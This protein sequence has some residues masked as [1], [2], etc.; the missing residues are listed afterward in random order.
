VVLEELGV[1]MSEED[2]FGG[3][4]V[5]GEVELVVSGVSLETFLLTL[6]VVTMFCDM[7]ISL[8]SSYSPK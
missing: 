1:G 6:L 4:E 2:Y 7:C 5:V 3:V 8:D